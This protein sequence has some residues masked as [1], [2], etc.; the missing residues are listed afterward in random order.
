MFSDAALDELES[1]RRLYDDGLR[2]TRK[3]VGKQHLGDLMFPLLRLALGHEIAVQPAWRLA[4]KKLDREIA[5]DHKTIIYGLGVARMAIDRVPG[6]KPVSR[7][8]M[9]GTLNTVGRETRSSALAKISALSDSDL[10]LAA[11]EV[12]TVQ[13]N[14]QMIFRAVSWVFGRH[15]FGQGHAVRLFDRYTHDQNVGIA[16]LYRSRPLGSD[17]G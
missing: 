8:H 4:E 14:H 1:G 13:K 17:P 2:L 16:M 15:A 3:M 6:M 12:A 10:K 11:R 9:I 5:N 7:Q